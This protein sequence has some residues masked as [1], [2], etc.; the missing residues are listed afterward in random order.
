MAPA[1]FVVL[2][3]QYIMGARPNVTVVI[4]AKIP[5]H[6]LRAI[7]VMK[8]GPKRRVIHQRAVVKPAPYIDVPRGIMAVQQPG[9][10]AVHD[11]RVRIP[12]IYYRPLAQPTARVQQG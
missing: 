1:K 5:A 4:I 8:E 11:A 2:G 9:R 7:Q 12:R 6:G 3:P 10:R